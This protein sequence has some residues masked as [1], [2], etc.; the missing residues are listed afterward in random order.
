MT[1]SSPRLSRLHLPPLWTLILAAAV[2]AVVVAWRIVGYRS[3]GAT[4]VNF[5]SVLWPGLVAIVAVYGIAWLGWAL[6]IDS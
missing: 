5:L 1:D 4:P 6:D 2:G 3:T